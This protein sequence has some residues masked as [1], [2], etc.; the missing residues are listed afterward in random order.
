MTKFIEKAASYAV[1]RRKF[2]GLTSTA[3]AGTAAALTLPGCGLSP[4]QST[5]LQTARGEGQWITAACWHN[6]GGRC[7][8]KAYVVDGMVL[9]QK[10]D[11]THADSPEYPQQRGCARG[12][13]QRTQ[14]LGADRLKYPMKR[15]HWEPGGGR[16]ELRGKD[17]WVRISWDEALD[18]VASE[19]KRITAK[20]GNSAIFIPSGAELTRTLSLYGGYAVRWGLVSWGTWPDVY[21]R[22]TGIKANGANEGNDRFRLWDSKLIILWGANPAVSSHGNPAYNYLQ[23]KKAGAK[24]I[25]VDPLYTDSARALA[26]DWIPCRPATDT[27]LI[28][29][30]AYHLIEH[31]LHDQD[32]LDKYCVG[33]DAD[34]MPEGADP[35]ENFKDY[36]LGTFDG[37]P[38]TPE[39]AAAICGVEPSRIRRFAEEYAFSKPAAIITGGAPARINNGEHFPHAVLTLGLMTGNTG[40]A[41]SGVSPNMH[42]RSTYAG[43]ALISAGSGGLPAIANPIAKIRLNNCEMWDAVLT[44][45][46]TDGTGPKKDINIQMICHGAASELNQRAGLM[47]G[48]EAHRKVEFVL[49]QNYVL[50][51]NALYSDVVLPVT[52]QWEVDGGTIS[53]NREMLIYYS[54]VIEPLFEAKE[55]MWIAEEVG[56]RLGLDGKLINP[57]STIQMTFNQIAGAKVIKEDGSGM[58]TLVTITEADI[59]EL[60]VSGK[61]QTGRISYKEFKEKGIYQVPRSRGDILE[62]TSFEKFIKDPEANKLATPSGKFQIYSQE[63]SD[64]IASFGWTPKSPLPKYEPSIE[65]YEDGLKDGYPYQLVTIHYPRRSHSTLDNIPWLREAFIQECWINGDDAKE[66]GLKTGDIAKVTSRHGVVIRP[67]YVT[68]RIMPGVIAIGEGAWYDADEQAGVDK[69]GA[70]NTLNGD[71]PTGQGHTGHNSCNV[72]VQKYDKTLEPDYQWPQRIV[73]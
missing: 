25:T 21:P 63:L 6:C 68:E 33:F 7:L 52:T 8:N 36:V 41:G 34:H 26:D 14:V 69:A 61:P 55:D 2:L 1:S 17:E 64:H 18:I 54:K 31:N 39:W 11:D 32:Y 27:T 72:R 56:K 71:I 28:L 42:A 58:E 29:G 16:K 30:M 9:R 15:K 23:A 37:I 10:T 62:Y 66:L 5:P 40:I 67:V 60:G 65:G 49:T 20:Y 45:K 13:S 19:I 43:P 3:L 38:K 22:I 12:R 73:F 50:N 48:I 46:Y 24:I 70:T 47:K 44:G 57:L 53:G 59:A 4:A 51:T 35:N